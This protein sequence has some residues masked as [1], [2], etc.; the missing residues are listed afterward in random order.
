MPRIAPADAARRVAAVRRIVAW[1]TAALPLVLFLVVSV[2]TDATAQPVHGK[3]IV[4]RNAHHDRSAPLRSMR[5]TY[6]SPRA[7]PAL[8]GPRSKVTVSA[9]DTSS[10]TGSALIPTANVNFD[11]I[12]ADGVAPPNANGA[13]GANEFVEL[14]DSEFAVYSKTGAVLLSPRATNT[15]WSGFGG[16]CQTNNDGDGTVLWDTLSQRWVIQQFS[17]STTPYLECIAVSATSD[18]TGVW[19]R[20]SFAYTNFPDYPKLGVWPDAY[21]ASFNMYNPAGTTAL[22]AE[23]CA[24]N[25]AAMIAGAAATQQ[26]FMATTNGADTFLPASLDGTTPP[27]AGEPEWFVG[28]SPTSA[29]ALAYRKFHVDWQTPA[30][31]TLTT[32]PDLPVAAF[33]EACGGGTCIPQAGTTQQ[34]DSI[35]DRLMYR[36]EYRNF[37]DHEAMVVTHAV[38]AG[39][40]VGMRWYELRPSAGAL[41]VFQQGT[42]APDSKYRWMGSIAMDH[43]G[44][45]ALGYSVSSSSLHPEIAYT[46]RLAGDPAGTMPQGESVIIAGAGSQSGGS[47][48]AW[49]YYTSMAVDPADDCTFWYVNQYEPTTGAVNWNTRIAAFRFPGCGGTAANDFS[50]SASPS[51]V[52]T[53]PGGTATSTIS[54]AVTN[55]SAQSVSLSASGLPPGTTA[56]LS[57]SSITA[58]SAATLTLS[59]AASTPAG[60]YSVT[61]TG[62]G[63]SVTH[64]T[65][66]TLTVSGGGTGAI[67]NGGFE[68]GTLSGWTPTG[69]ASVTTSAPHSGS[70]VAMVGSTSPTNGDSSI[71][72][73]F[74]AAAGTNELTFWYN[75]TCPDTL[76]YDWATA[77]LTDNTTGTTSTPLARTCVAS[78]GWRAVSVA[79]TA[80]HSYTLTL[81][82]HDD[83]YPGDATYTK[84]DDVGLI[85]SANDF[86]L[87]ASPTTVTVSQGG[88][89]TSTVSTALTSGAA[90]TVSLSASGLPAGASASFSPPSLTSGGSSTLT[91]STVATTPTGTYPVTVTGTGTSATHSTTVTLAVNPAGGLTNG[92]FEAGTLSGWT[93]S[94]SATVTSTGAHSGSYTALVGSASPTNGDS[95]IRQTFTVPAGASQLSFWYDVTCPDTVTYDW[96]TATLTD[97]TTG[98]STTPLPR[99]CVNPSGWK[100]VTSPVTSGHSYT[101][102]LISH[103]DNYKGDAT[104][105][106]YDEVALG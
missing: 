90:Q 48:S 80:G 17:V 101:L 9:R 49:G 65:S 86:S 21:Y 29:N 16:G 2:T 106:T 38:A 7:H 102:T 45:M 103:D 87:S 84:F 36:L 15:L 28:L 30:N 85:A 60:T 4:T 83:N 89:G 70:Y 59:T 104:Y 12:A 62:T 69:T 99:T 6:T 82:S 1:L 54:T 25:R 34:L 43:L 24:F 39:S 79:V 68:T 5:N 57:P 52:T 97:N 40:S 32:A 56:S 94:G 33:S 22:G 26:C 100:Q 66:V 95:Y 72:Q 76:T 42:Y 73:T 18:A 53:S 14:V 37:G 27:P 74:T 10:T 96:A 92:G 3:P 31:S 61:V 75:V 71:K 67:P 77:T 64:T 11:G 93:A 35:G 78:S 46:G 63:S 44:D 81:I 55:G 20:Y 88:S 8:H 19:Y 105:T 41:T 50:M 13:A 91:L 58:G 47:L 51:S 23:L 98:T